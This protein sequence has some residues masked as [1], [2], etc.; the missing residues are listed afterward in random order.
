MRSKGECRCLVR[1]RPWAWSSSTPGGGALHLV[2]AQRP[3]QT[4]TLPAAPPQAEPTSM[5]EPASSETCERGNRGLIIVV[6]MAPPL[7]RRLPSRASGGRRPL[8]Q[9]S[10]HRAHGQPRHAGRVGD[11]RPDGPAPIRSTVS[12]SPVEPASDHVDVGHHGHV[13]VFEVVAVHHV[14]A[15]EAREPDQHLH[16]PRRAGGRRCPS[17]RRRRA[18]DLR[19]LRVSTWKWPRWT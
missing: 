6:D 4:R 9:E 19:P 2:L 18:R 1:R 11:V 13:L 12:M 5:I 15:T 17:S 8:P 14:A 16:R 7:R 3:G 10:N